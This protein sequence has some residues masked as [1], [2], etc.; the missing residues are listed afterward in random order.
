MSVARQLFSLAFRK[1]CVGKHAHK[2]EGAAQAH[3]RA[4]VQLGRAEADNIRAYR[5]PYCNRWHVGHYAR[6]SQTQENKAS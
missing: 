5:C 6:R 3:I 4:L 2:S 1:K